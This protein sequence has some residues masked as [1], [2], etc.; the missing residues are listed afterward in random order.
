MCGKGAGRSQR[1]VRQRKCTA[2]GGRDAVKALVCCMA[3]PGGQL[4][5]HWCAP[6]VYVPCE[7]RGPQVGCGNVAATGLSDH[8]EE[9]LQVPLLAASAWP[10]GRNTSA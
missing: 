3:D 1:V 9:Q 5:R 7:I 6:C 4:C 2:Q 10:V 8:T